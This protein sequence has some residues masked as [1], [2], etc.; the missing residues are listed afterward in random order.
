MNPCWDVLG[1]GIVAVDDL[2]YVDHFPIRDTK[3]PMLAERRQG[4]GL[5]GTALVAAARLGAKAAYCGVM[6]TEELAAF[7]IQ[8]LE[9]EGV[10]CSPVLRQAGAR[11]IHAVI[12]VEPATGQRTILFTHEGFVAPEPA[13]ITEALVASCRVLLMD[14]YAGAGGVRAAEIARRLGI[15]FVADIERMDEPTTQALFRLSDHLIVRLDSGWRFLIAAVLRA[16]RPMTTICR[17]SAMFFSRS[18]SAT[19]ASARGKSHK[20]TLSGAAGRLLRTRLRYMASAMNGT[21]GARQ[22]GHRFQNRIEGHIGVDLVLV[23][24]RL[25]EPFAAASDV[26]VGQIVGKRL[27]SPS[28]SCDVIIFEQA[29]DLGDQGVQAAEDP[30][31]EDAQ[32]GAV[33]GMVLGLN[34]S[35]RA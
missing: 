29:V 7:T 2:F 30:A 12:I 28:G 8:E 23:H 21:K 17:T 3:M 18:G 34:W 27:D 13:Q 25:P 1:L 16:A 20:C 15:P 10:D 19:A 35:M 4:G 22:A 24:L 6:G 9:R 32:A 11:P 33:E 5:T 26:P 14:G 31:I